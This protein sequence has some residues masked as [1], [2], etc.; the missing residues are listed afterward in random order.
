MSNILQLPA[1]KIRFLKWQKKTRTTLSEHVGTFADLKDGQTNAIIVPANTDS[2]TIYVA[3]SG[4]DGNAGTSAAPVLTLTAAVALLDGTK[5]Q[6]I[7]QDS[8]EYAQP[9]LSNSD[10]DFSVGQFVPSARHAWIAKKR[11]SG[12]YAAADQ[13]PTIT[14]ANPV[15]RLIRDNGIAAVFNFMDGTFQQS[16]NITNSYNFLARWEN[17][18]ITRATTSSNFV[19]INLS[20]NVSNNYTTASTAHTDSTIHQIAVS[21]SDDILIY[22][23]SFGPT[24]RMM[25]RNLETGSEASAWAPAGLSFFLSMIYPPLRTDQENI[26]HAILTDAPSGVQ[27]TYLYRW[28]TATGSPALLDGS[29]LLPEWEDGGEFEQGT[30]WLLKE[31]VISENIMYLLY[32]NLSTKKQRIVSW[33]IRNYG[34]ALGDYEFARPITQNSN[35]TILMGKV[36][37]STQ[38]GLCRVSPTSYDIVVPY[39]CESIAETENG[40]IYWYNGKLRY[41]DSKNFDLLPI[42]VPFV[43]GE[44]GDEIT[45]SGTAAGEISYFKDMSMG[46]VRTTTTRIASYAIDLSL[47]NIT[48]QVGNTLVTPD[49]GSLKLL[50]HSHADDDTNWSTQDD[51]TG[52]HEITIGAGTPKHRNDIT[53]AVGRSSVKFD[54]SSWLSVADN[55]S[56]FDSAL[57]GS[58]SVDAWVYIATAQAAATMAIISTNNSA[59]ANGHG[60]YVGHL[61]SNRIQFLLNGTQ[62]QFTAAPAT[63]GWGYDKWMH[64][65]IYREGDKI[66]AHCNGFPMACTL[67]TTIDATTHQNGAA[68]TGTDRVDIGQR[69][70]GTSRWTGYADELFFASA[71]LKHDEPI[72]PAFDIG[73]RKFISSRDGFMPWIDRKYVDFVAGFKSTSTLSGQYFTIQGIKLVAK[74]AENVIRCHQQSTPI[75][76]VNCHVDANNAVRAFVGTRFELIRTEAYNAQTLIDSGE[77]LSAVGGESEFDDVFFNRALVYNVGTVIDKVRAAMG[78]VRCELVESTI[79][80]A[81]ILRMVNVHLSPNG[82]RQTTFSSARN[83]THGEIVAQF[84]EDSV[85]TVKWIAEGS[86]SVNGNT[87]TD[88]TPVF[89]RRLTSDMRLRLPQDGFSIWTFIK[90]APLTVLNYGAYTRYT[91]TTQTSDWGIFDFPRLDQNGGFTISHDMAKRSENTTLDGTYDRDTQ[92]PRRFIR[93]QWHPDQVWTDSEIARMMDMME[94]DHWLELIIQPIEDFDSADM[95]ASPVLVDNSDDGRFDTK[96]ISLYLTNYPNIIKRYDVGRFLSLVKGTGPD[97]IRSVMQVSDVSDTVASLKNGYDKTLYA[98]FETWDDP[99]IE[100]PSG[101]HNQKIRGYPVRIRPDSISFTARSLPDGEISDAGAFDRQ[102]L[103]I[104]LVLELDFRGHEVIK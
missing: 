19:F 14:Q 30:D 48:H 3:K 78:G 66:R 36:Y 7:I 10:N 28:D 35:L 40:I 32:T 68:I 25:R 24:V 13:T 54:G 73:T 90:S 70:N 41:L 22:V 81:G 21:E 98:A 44:T 55:L 17:T 27:T 101:A 69:T 50:I 72:A 26:R 77:L 49:H 63:D 80:D 57:N 11:F 64:W 38:E 47:L 33:S 9:I 53:P 46:M 85:A 4:D 95:P 92:T 97:A 5:H 87:N 12:I 62:A 76:L 42:G 39:E 2:N 52:R 45:W 75:R 103:S 71:A 43:H 65:R 94:L 67:G 37:I 8:G 100:S 59:S 83:A 34:K 96:N 84:Y 15:A 74:H 91:F 88:F 58:F 89:F 99:L 93:L 1:D 60:F 18:M 104:D 56:D 20:R 6:I 51:H 23:Q 86:F 29:G 16:N 102:P 31:W 79:H 82:A 61:S